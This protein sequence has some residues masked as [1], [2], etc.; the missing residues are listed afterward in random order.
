MDMHDDERLRQALGLLWVPDHGRDYRKR[1]EAALAAA[2]PPTAIGER[3][4]RPISRRMTII[5]AAAAVCLAVAVLGAVLSTARNSGGTKAGSVSSPSQTG[6]GKTVAG[7]APLRVGDD[8]TGMV[9]GLDGELWAWGYRYRKGSPGT[10]LLERW[11]GQSWQE[12]PTPS[13]AIEGVAALSSN[14]LWI[15]EITRRRGRLVHWDGANWKAFPAIAFASTTETS[16][17]LLALSPSDIWAVG[18]A[19]SAAAGTLKYSRLTTLHWDGRRWSS[20][21]AP[22]FGRGIG[23]VSLRLI[24][25]VSPDAVWALGDYQ[26]YR[27]ETVEGKLKWVE[28]RSAQFLLF[29]DGRRWTRQPWPTSQPSSGHKDEIAINDLAVA[30]DGELWC[31]GSRWFGPDNTSDLWVPVVLRLQAGRWQ[32]MASSATPSL[33]AN[34]KQFMSNSI[35][36]TSPQDVWVAGNGTDSSGTH[37][38]LWHWDGSAWSVVKLGE[39]QSPNRVFARSV[40]AVAAND[41]WVLTQGATVSDTL[42]QLEPF[43][44]HFDGAAW[45]RVPAAPYAEAQR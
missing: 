39:V 22:A 3:Q 8:L 43:F 33:P 10:P 40:L 13:G 37:S 29:W 34:W 19:E 6:P 27:Q 14:D 15:A 21:P 35:S 32:V 31:T 42:E 24:R 23:E 28:T 38:S 18:W 9:G 1:R 30:S 17:A 12:F 26:R 41:I 44:V 16:N 5:A 25:G 7:R 11:D 2:A 45:R 36:L 20:V 4:R